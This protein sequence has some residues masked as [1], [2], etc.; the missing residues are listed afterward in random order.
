MKK[1]SILLVAFLTVN[2]AFAQTPT[3]KVALTK[4]QKIQAE[5]S[6]SIEAS[7]SM[8]MEIKNNSTSE[9][10]LEVKDVSTNATAIDNT[11]KKLKVDMDMMGKAMNYDSEK[12][13]DQTSDLG[14][15]LAGKINVPVEVAVDNNTGKAIMDKKDSPE[16][17]DESMAQ[18][19]SIMQLFGAT[20]SEDPVSG[21]FALIPQGKKVGDTWTDSTSDKNSKTV[22]TFT[23]KSITGDE[24]MLQ[25]NS[26]IDATSD[27]EMQGMQMTFVTTAKTTG[28]VTTDIK[29]ALVKKKTTVTE[30][31]GNFQVAGQEVP[32]NAKTT[33][34]ATYK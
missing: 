12:P 33:Y 7:L 18:M 20:T 14:K 24:A 11:L 32:I 26:V 25:I 3:N 6:V 30:T 15:A 28:D 10:A 17:P 8:G 34:T 4:G 9:I 29:T 21:A 31:T 19:E 22:R 13:E 5:I 23:L 27:L 2:L 16:K 1:I